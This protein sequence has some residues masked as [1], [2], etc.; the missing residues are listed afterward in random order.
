M[1]R[2]EIGRKPMTV[3]GFDG[4]GRD[5]AGRGANSG[6]RT[7]TGDLRIMRPQS[8]CHKSHPGNELTICEEPAAHHLP[9]GSVWPLADKDLAH[10]VEHWAQIQ[11]EMRAGIIAMVRASLKDWR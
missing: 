2:E 8:E 11:P 10:L 3:A 7:R 6:V 4:L 5:L 1:V 9:T